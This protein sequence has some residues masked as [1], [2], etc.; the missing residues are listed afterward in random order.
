MKLVDLT[1]P[2]QTEQDGRPTAAP[3]RLRLG[4]GM[5]SY[6]AVL[7]D[8]AHDS[9][10]GTYLDL[11]GHIAETDDG[12]DAATVPVERL[13][14]LRAAVLHLSRADGSGGIGATELDEVSAGGG[15]PEALVINALGAVRFDEIEERSVYLELDAV[16]WII[17][18]GVKLVV[19]DVY[20]SRA[21]HGV[22]AALFGAGIM[23]VCYPVN[24]HELTAPE[25]R[26]TV[27]PARFP[28][29]TQLPCRVVAEVP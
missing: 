25:V 3:R 5:A 6:T 10:V 12:Q 9:M 11:P 21:L 7:Y 8:F 29:V 27:L 26:L 14:R 22:F 17:A 18:S 15:C 28:G 1:L 13:Y 2:I 16:E 4:H 19:A 20:E 24:L 23:A